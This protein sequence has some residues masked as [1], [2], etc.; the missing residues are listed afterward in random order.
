M[1]P[2]VFI[3]SLF[4]AAC[5]LPLGAAGQ[6]RT[7]IS[8]E[9]FDAADSRRLEAALVGFPDLSRFSLTDSSG[10]ARLQDLPA[11]DY[12][13]EVT[14]LG[15]DRATDTLH[16]E[17]GDLGQYEVAMNVQPFEIQGITVDGLSR[18]SSSLQRGGFYARSQAGVGRFFDRTELRQRMGMWSTLGR[19]LRGRLM[20]MCQPGM[21][22][23]PRADRGANSFRSPDP[24][25]RKGNSG[26]GTRSSAVGS[27]ADAGRGIT[28]LV[29]VDGIPWSGTLEE[30][31]YD[32]VE[33]LEIYRS[34]SNIPVQYAS[35]AP[36][37]VVLVWMTR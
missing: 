33:G 9:V 3:A 5:L 18:W 19:A 36:C 8:V 11:G 10:T 12:R 22:Y 21:N 7:S 26:I 35:W 6:A 20:G 1:R 23:G 4:V 37:G 31:P 24:M 27:G 15:Y 2:S 32:W 30:I 25:E 13:L 17:A 29:F 14:V 34:S 16:L 28:P